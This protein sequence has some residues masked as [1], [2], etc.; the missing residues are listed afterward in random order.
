MRQTKFIEKQLG[1]NM[2]RISRDKIVEV[3]IALLTRHDLSA[4]DIAK[5]SNVRLGLVYYINSGKSERTRLILKHIIRNDEFPIRK[6]D[7]KTK[8]AEEE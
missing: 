7:W 2:A 6:M 4:K 8:D 3:G 1:Y 5:L